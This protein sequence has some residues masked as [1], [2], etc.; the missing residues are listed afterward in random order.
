MVHTTSFNFL[1][2]IYVLNKAF[3]SKLTCIAFARSS[4]SH[5]T[6]RYICKT[7]YRFSHNEKNLTGSS[8]F[9]FLGVIFSNKLERWSNQDE[10]VQGPVS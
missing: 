10:F 1:K 3:V 9:H 8:Y 2:I 4:L 5:H 6:S 7:N